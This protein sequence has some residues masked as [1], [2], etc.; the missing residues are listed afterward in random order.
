M[1]KL[2]PAEQLEQCFDVSASEANYKLKIDFDLNSSTLCFSDGC[3][4]PL[5]DLPCEVIKD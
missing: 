4:E 5:R 1:D 2:S 3:K